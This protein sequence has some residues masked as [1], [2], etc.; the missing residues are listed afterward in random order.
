MIKPGATK[1]DWEIELSDSKSRRTYGLKIPSGSLQI[2]TVSQDDTVYVRNVGKR[3]GDFDEQR[4]WKGG[5]G[6][7]KLSDNAEGFYDSM[8]AWTLSPGHV[9]QTMQWYHTRGLRNE[10]VY[11]PTRDS[12]SV[13]FQPL[14]GATRYISNSF[15]ASASYSADKAFLWVRRKGTPG[16]LTFVLASNSSGSPGS[17]LQTVTK[18]VSDITDYVSVYEVFD[19]TGTESLTSGTTYHLYV[20]GASTDN[21]DNHWEVGINPDAASG[22]I[23]TNGSTWEGNTVAL[24]YRVTDADTARKWY[25]FNLRGAMYIIDQKDNNSTASVLY[26]NGDRGKA[27]AGASSTITDSAKSWVTDRWA[28][29]WVRIISGTGV[30]NTPKK[31]LSN[32]GTVLTIDGTWETTPSTDSL[33]VIYA[34]EWWTQITPSGGSLS[35]CSG[36]PQVANNV[37]YIPQ[38]STGI[39]HLQ[40]NTS[41]L[42][43]DISVE[44]A[45]GTNG[46]ADLLLVAIDQNDGVVIWRVNNSSGTGSGG[47]F[48]ASK[49]LLISS[50]AYIAW[51]TALT[52]QTAI[53]IGTT[54][55]TGLNRKDALVYV[56]SQDG[57]GVVSGGKYATIDTGAEKTPDITNGSFSISHGQ[58]FY[59]S[60]LHSVI[61]IYGS[62][63]DDVGDDYRSI[64]LPDGRE[65]VYA[66]GDTYLKMVLFAVDAGSAGWSSVLTFDGIGWHEIVR[67]RRVGERVRFVKVQPCQ[68]TRNRIWTQSGSDLIFQELPFKK[69][70]PR[71]D[72]GARYQHEAVIVSSVIDMGTASSMPKLIKNLTATVKNLN[73][74]GHEV[75]VDA[76]WDDNCHTDKWTP[77]GVMTQSPESQIFLGINATR[78][79]YRLRMFTQDN[80]IPIDIEGIVPNGY[81]RT[82]Y[83]MIWTFQIQAGGI[84]SRRGKQATAGE[85]MRWL[86][87]QSRQAGYVNMSSVYELAH[88]WRVVIHPPRQFPMTPRK[89]T[90]PET[91]AL[92]LTLQEV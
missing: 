26:I 2:G 8:N 35:V 38:G 19:W 48:T 9:H 36:E 43:H 61:R 47:Q 40:Y 77:I 24:Y 5:R 23:S 62:T 55:I 32:T 67:A 1:Y 57:L 44:S 50:G 86:L 10:D 6:T 30:R 34:T 89:G 7:E 28:N 87:D 46:L 15:S 42:A 39:A 14:I 16:T 4:S 79:V 58:F 88:G 25:R 73:Q 12:G 3:V 20:Y 92:T 21:K 31:I 72:S 76:Q 59:Y 60:W 68:G 80:S 90:T 56:F 82:P 51:N 66:D 81:A 49:A 29:A 64:G 63:H 69:S 45:S 91:A 27:T 78:F 41:T 18:T 37:V 70:A 84:Y 54:P 65:G 75:F 74:N 83:K 11:M 53:Q 85:L 17:A 33:Y 13:R 52:F 22:Q 71:L